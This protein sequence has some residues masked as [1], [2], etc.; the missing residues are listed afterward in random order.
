MTTNASFASAAFTP[1]RLI[2][3]NP[4]LLSSFKAILLSGQNLA[5]GTVL[6]RVAGAVGSAVAAGA[7]SSGA[8][9]GNGVF[10]AVTLGA[11]AKEGTYRIVFVEPT[12]DLGK[13]IVE[14]PDGVIVGEGTVGTAFAGPINFT[15]A[16]GSADFISGDGF[17]VAVAQGTKY[18][19]S[20]AAATDGS[21]IPV[22]ILAE[23]CDATAG[24][25]SCLIYERGD[26]A[27]IALTLGTGHTV[28]S[29]RAGLAAR[30][31]LIVTVQPA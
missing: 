5:R 13:F 4:D 29:I 20:A 27:D 28:A 6:G 12:T 2:A 19:K 17:T 30:G 26:F 21:Q 7:G 31:I 25:A 24:D 9:T 22:G 11:S 15:I 23:D 3:R 14:D 10:G 18:V 16:D 1:D 8:N